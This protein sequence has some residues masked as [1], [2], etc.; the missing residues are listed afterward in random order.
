[1]KQ[2]DFIGFHENRDV[3]IP[4]LA[5]AINLPLDASFLR[6]KTTAILERFEVMTSM[7]IRQQLNDLLSE[8]LAFYERLRNRS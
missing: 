8:D 3:D 7:S 1:M 5:Q 2:F 6:N 4:R